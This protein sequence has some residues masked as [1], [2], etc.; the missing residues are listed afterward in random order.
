VQKD[1]YLWRLSSKE[2]EKGFALFEL[3]CFLFDE[4]FEG[5]SIKAKNFH[6][7]QET[8]NLKKKT[9]FLANQVSQAFSLKSLC[10]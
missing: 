1:K 6:E 2:D 4:V 7:K 8:M 5:E 10:C 9:C 3:F